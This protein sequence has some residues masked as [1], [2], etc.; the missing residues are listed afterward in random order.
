MTPR[1]AIFTQNV[2]TGNYHQ[3]PYF[4]VENS[5]FLGFSGGPFPTKNGRWP[6]PQGVPKQGDSYI[7]YTR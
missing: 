7:L 5:G 1:A 2:K 6:R 3:K 4:G